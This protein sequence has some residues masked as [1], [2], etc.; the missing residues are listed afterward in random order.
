[1]HRRCA[2]QFSALAALGLALLPVSAAGQ[3]KSLK[4]QLVGAWTLLIDDNVRSDGTQT[5]MF[6]PNPNGIVI[7]DTS[8]HG[9]DAAEAAFQC[10][11]AGRPEMGDVCS[12]RE[13]RRAVLLE[14]A[15]TGGTRYNSR[16]RDRGGGEVMNGLFDVA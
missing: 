12:L 13:R 2:L 6:G 14:E 7:F 4:D 1:M 8:G 16:H 10:A 11:F 9:T 5:P 15:Q 3:Q